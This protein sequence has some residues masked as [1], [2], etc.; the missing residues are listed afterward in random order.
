MHNVAD[1]TTNNLTIPTENHLTIPGKA[2]KESDACYHHE[3][4]AARDKLSRRHLAG[5]ACCHLVRLV[6]RVFL[7]VALNVAVLA[8]LLLSASDALTPAGLVKPLLVTARVLAGV[9]QTTDAACFHRFLEQGHNT[10]H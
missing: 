8:G 10:N 1:L 6:I 4:Q 2:S 9:G 5:R 7:L 3:K